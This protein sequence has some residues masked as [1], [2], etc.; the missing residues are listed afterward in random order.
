MCVQVSMLVFFFFFFPA[1]ETDLSFP[2]VMLQREWHHLEPER[3][4]STVFTV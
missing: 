3:K 1:T 2:L 4:E